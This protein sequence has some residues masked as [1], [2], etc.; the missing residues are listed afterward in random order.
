MRLLLSLLLFLSNFSLYANS[1]EYII[2][3]CRENSGMFSIFMDVLAL[4]KC[5]EKGYYSGIEVD[6]GTSGLYY[7]EEKGPNWWEYYCEKIQC[8]NGP[9]RY[10]IGDP[11]FSIPWQS[12]FHTS[13]KEAFQLIEKYIHIKFD[14]K[15][16]IDDFIYDNF[17][18]KF[19]IGIHYRGTDKISEAP[20][21]SYATVFFEILNAIVLNGPQKYK[22][23]IATDEWAFIQ[24]LKGH[25][26]DWVCYNEDAIRSKNGTPVHL[27]LMNNRYKCGQ[28][29]LID[30]MLLSKTNYLIRMSSNLSLW[31]TFFNPELEVVELNKRY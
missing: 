7:D 25:F 6:F 1:K 30:C 26:G 9:K 28:D 5:H 19:V 13:R 20:L 2:L 14:I 22:I 27:N 29:A 21:V 17:E 11:P 18:D 24:Y 23:F 8:G 12:E 3:G 10:V 31:S 15:T 4:L 16:I